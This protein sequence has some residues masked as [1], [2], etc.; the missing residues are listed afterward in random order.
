MEC[1]VLSQADVKQCID[2]QQ[3]IAAMESAFKQYHHGQVE[4]PLRTSV[5]IKEE[6]ALTLTMPAYLSGEKALG[7]KVVSVFPNNLAR[8]K[9]VINGAILLLNEQTG[10]VQ[11]LMEAGWLTALRTGAVSGLATRYLAREDATHLAIIGSGV[12]AMTQL[13][14]VC[15]LRPIDKISIWSRDLKK[16]QAMAKNIDRSYDVACYQ[17]IPETV[18]D[19]DVICTATASTE[20]LIQWQDVKPDAHINAVGSHNLLMRELGNDLMAKAVVV[21]DQLQAALAES[22]EVAA[23]I[24]AKC[25]SVED[26]VELGAVVCGQHPDKHQ[27][28]V[29]KSVGL[30]IQDISI[31]HVVYQNALKKGLGT[32]LMMS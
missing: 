19:A 1:M 18:K 27:L 17:T 22:G 24:A 7:L 30:A 32:K 16:A 25:L 29:F 5:S 3:A 21:V 26:I 15:A 4:L 9:A 6:E 8:N 13:Q 28:T 2:M 31:A 23:A 14:A 12:Q 10:E 20:A 11:A